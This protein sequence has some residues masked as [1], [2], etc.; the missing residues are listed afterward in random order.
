MGGSRKSL[1][2]GTPWTNLDDLSTNVPFLWVLTIPRC[3]HLLGASVDRHTHLVGG[4]DHRH[5]ALARQSRAARS[6][7]SRT[8]L[9][10]D[11]INAGSMIGWAPSAATGQRC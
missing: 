2:L 8:S 1:A 9:A 3:R 5:S 4:L 7:P 10:I 6:M 11:I